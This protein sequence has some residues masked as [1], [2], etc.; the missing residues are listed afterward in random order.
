MI[1]DLKN[2]KLLNIADFISVLPISFYFDA[3]YRFLSVPSYNSL[4]YLTGIFAAT[5]AVMAASYIAAAILLVAFPLAALAP[6]YQDAKHEQGLFD[7]EQD[8]KYKEIEGVN[9]E[10]QEQRDS[11]PDHSDNKVDKA[12][13]KFKDALDRE[14][15]TKGA[16]RIF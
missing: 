4:K 7:L 14:R 15:D 10:I 3:F 13:K 16:P 6:G 2:F 11:L 5:M 9:K 1:A 8:K 12:A